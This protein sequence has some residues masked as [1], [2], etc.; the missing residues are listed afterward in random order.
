M[1][2][3]VIVPL[4]KY[5]GDADDPNNYRGTTLLSCLGKLFTSII[6]DR[7]TKFSNRYD[8]VQETQAEFR[9][10]YSTLDHFFLLKNIIDLLLWKKKKL[11]FLF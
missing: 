7:L 3:G 9:Q 5:K 6:N 8:I 11:F 2:I 1:L 4:Y 10:G